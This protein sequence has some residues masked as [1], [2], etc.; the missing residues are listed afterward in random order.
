VPLS[1]AIVSHPEYAEFAG[2]LHKESAFSASSILVHR[3]FVPGKRKVF[4]VS[5]LSLMLVLL[6]FVAWAS[7]IHGP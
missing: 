4:G 1:V 2:R 5:R 3:R 6:L 7:T